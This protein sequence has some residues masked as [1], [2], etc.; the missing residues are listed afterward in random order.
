MGQDKW[1]EIVFVDEIEQVQCYIDY[2]GNDQFLY[3]LVIKMFGVENQGSCQD[4][5]FWCEGKV[6][7]CVFGLCN[8][9]GVE[10]Y[11]FVE[12]SVGLDNG[13]LYQ[14]DG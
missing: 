14:I 10:E 1:L 11:F 2:V 9:D 3:V 7:K 8:Q 6:V 13:Y 5:Q 12:G 4:C